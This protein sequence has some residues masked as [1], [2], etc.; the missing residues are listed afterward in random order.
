MVSFI[1][2]PTPAL[3][4]GTADMIDPV[5]DGIT[6][7]MPPA[8][9]IITG[10]NAQYDVSMREMVNRNMAH[11]THTSP[12]ATTRLVPNFA[13]RRG[14]FGASTIITAANGSCFTPAS[15]VP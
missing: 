8:I 5:I 10:S 9:V 13:A 7:A 4:S 2:E 1:A 15:S 6:S 14:E 3:P 12:N 11:E